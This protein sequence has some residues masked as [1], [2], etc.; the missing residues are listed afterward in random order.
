[1]VGTS[2]QNAVCWA[3]SVGLCGALFFASAAPAA[4]T[5][6]APS[7]DALLEQP[8]AELLQEAM[9]LY[10]ALEYDRVIPYASA[11]LAHEDST[12]DQKLDAYLLQGSA[13][14][15]VGDPIEAETPFRFLLRG[16]PDFDLPP[17]TPPKILAVFRKVQVEEQAIVQTTRALERLRIIRT[18]ELETNVAKTS[19]GGDPLPFVV[20]LRDPRGAVTTVKVLYRKEGERAWSALALQPDG[21]GEWA[22]VLPGASTAS[23]DGFILEYYFSTADTDGQELLVRGTAEQ[24]YRTEVSPGSVK[25]TAS[26]FYQS[27]WFW[28]AA[29]VVVMAV[30]VSAGGIALVSSL[31]PRGDL[32]V[33]PLD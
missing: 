6:R 31:P 16:R 33:L 3:L 24:P 13:F 14:A 18:L 5:K 26:A 29:G 30:A 28:G 32:G 20:R 4:R 19:E 9:R 27:P 17:E 15:V 21:G 1:M 10:E 25:T 2:R 11:V 22:N 8:P 12:V 23:D 7:V